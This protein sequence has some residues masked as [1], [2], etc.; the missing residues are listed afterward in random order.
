[1]LAAKPRLHGILNRL[2]LL[3]AVTGVGSA[4]AYATTVER[5]S[6]PDMLDRA[7]DVVRVR[8]VENVVRTD[9]DTLY[10]WT[11]TTFQVV[12]SVKGRLRAG[13]L[14][15]VE[16]IG[17]EAPG[18]GYATVVAD[19]PRFDLDEEMVLF[20]Y[21]TRDGRRQP[22]GFYQGTVRLRPTEDGTGLEAILHQASVSDQLT[23]AGPTATAPLR[24]VG[25]PAP[26]ADPTVGRGQSAAHAQGKALG[27]NRRVMSADDFMA[28]LHAMVAAVQEERP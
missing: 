3:L 9:P 16:V 11:V 6:V 14:L 26:A 8:V 4:S 5:M 19:A 24:R 18:S 7:D 10:H 2:L 20:S 1:M 28:D 15:D 13:E 27:V 17:G 23:T 12:D 22:V 21:N 25:Q